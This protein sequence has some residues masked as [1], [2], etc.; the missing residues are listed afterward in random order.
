MVAQRTQH[1]QLLD[2]TDAGRVD[3]AASYLRERLRVGQHAGLSG[4]YAGYA[5]CGLL[6]TLARE[7][8]SGGLPELI[9]S[10]L[11]VL[12]ADL[13]SEESSRPLATQL[14]AGMS[15]GSRAAGGAVS[16]Q[17]CSVHRP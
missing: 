14:R 10:S 11:M 7:L 17:G 9:R 3:H 5:I 6:D 2:Q 4:V 8:R 1:Q 12:V 15:V 16:G 13:G